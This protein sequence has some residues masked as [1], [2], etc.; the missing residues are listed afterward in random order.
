LYLPIRGA[1][2][3]IVEVIEA[4][5][6]AKYIQDFIQHP[7]VKVNSICRGNCWGSSML[8][9]MQQVNYRSY[10]LQSLNTLEKW[11]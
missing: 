1:I 9:S 5:Y 10:I 3:E 6:F 11:E 8:I 7:T 2:K 4:Y